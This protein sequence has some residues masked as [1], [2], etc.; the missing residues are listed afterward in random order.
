M[1]TCGTATPFVAYIPSIT[2][3][4]LKRYRITTRT[5]NGTAIVRLH[6]FT[7]LYGNESYE[8]ILGTDWK[9]T[10]LDVIGDGTDSIDV[11]FYANSAVGSAGPCG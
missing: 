8:Q 5:K 7:G 2:T 9:I 4:N 11:R 1:Q 10:T 6:R 3:T